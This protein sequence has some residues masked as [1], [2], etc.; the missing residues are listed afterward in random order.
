MLQ[1]IILFFVLSAGQQTE[2]GEKSRWCLHRGW[3]YK[4]GTDLRLGT[5]SMGRQWAG[6]GRGRGEECV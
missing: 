5:E 1:P 3:L 6:R 4:H 2:A